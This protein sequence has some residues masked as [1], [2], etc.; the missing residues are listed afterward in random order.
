MS[1]KE[2]S[3]RS[4]S[5]RP[6]CMFGIF[7][8]DTWAA[9]AS[10]IAAVVSMFLLCY[11]LYTDNPN[12]QIHLVGAAYVDFEEY[13]ELYLPVWVT[14]FNKGKRPI[15]ILNAGLRIKFPENTLAIKETPIFPRYHMPEKGSPAQIESPFFYDPSYFENPMKGG[16]QWDL[17]PKSLEFKQRIFE[18]GTFRS[19]YIVFVLSKKDRTEFI[20]DIRRI[21]ISLEIHTTDGDMLVPVHSLNKWKKDTFEKRFLLIK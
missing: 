14:A 1:D 8:A 20:K 6:S 21:S 3:C 17:H 16:E 12:L 4:T 15:G 19:G 7:R 18:I 9:I 13:E 2:N 11:Q 5:E 10:S